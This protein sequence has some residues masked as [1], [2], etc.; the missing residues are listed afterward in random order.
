[1]DCFVFFPSPT[2]DSGS[3]FFA[4]TPRGQ[5]VLAIISSGYGTKCWEQD[6]PK[7]INGLVGV[8]TAELLPW[9]MKTVMNTRCHCLEQLARLAVRFAA[10]LGESDH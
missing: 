10:G 6:S 4:D 5:T 7:R 3:P 1:M 2:G 9:I 8:S